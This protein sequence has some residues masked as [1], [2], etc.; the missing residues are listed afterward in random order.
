MN[1]RVIELERAEE[2][3]LIADISDEALEAAVLAAGE[4]I[5]FTFSFNLFY[6]RFC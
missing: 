1:E 3:L 4:R 6:C 2:E 5:T